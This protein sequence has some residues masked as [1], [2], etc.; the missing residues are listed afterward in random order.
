MLDMDE[1]LTRGSLNRKHEEDTFDFSEEAEEVPDNK[2]S[3]NPPTSV[4]ITKTK[5]V[6]ISQY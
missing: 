6:K 5:D 2:S 1:W 4:Q 3:N